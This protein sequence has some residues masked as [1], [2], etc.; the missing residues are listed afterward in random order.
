MFLS[1]LH[2]GLSLLAHKFLQ[3]LLR[4]YE[5][6]LWQLTPNSILHL[7]IFITLCE[8]FLGIDPHFGLWK[9]IF[10]VKRYNSSGGSFVIGG[11]GFVA[12]KEVN[13]FNF[14]M[15]DSVQ[16]WR[17]KWFY[18]RD[19][20]TA[21]LQLPR[22]SDVLEAKPKQSWKNT[23]SPDE[24]PAV[25]RLFARFLRIK[26]ADGQTM[27]GTEVASVFLRRRVQPIMAR[28]HPMWLYSGPR[29]ETRINAAELSEKELLDE[30]RRLTHFSQEDSIPLTSSHVPF[31]VDHPP[32]EVISFFHTLIVSFFLIITTAIVLTCFIFDRTS[33][34][35]I[36]CK[37]YRTI[38]P[39]GE[40]PQSP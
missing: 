3:H 24:K 40:T 10:F 36:T 38:L 14:P 28:A 2:R 7:A 31:D 32:T 39:R 19:S 8:S 37:T 33:W 21:E 22:F 15:R 17:L 1:F 30:V 13:Y 29:D 27:I 23:L 26:E 11:V 6:Q 9:K 5:I 4:V 25:D 16:G 12:R 20:P 18:I 35:L 34:I